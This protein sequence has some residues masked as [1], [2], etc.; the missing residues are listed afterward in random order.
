MQKKL[1][2]LSFLEKKPKTDDT[3][4]ANN[5]STHEHRKNAQTIGNSNTKTNNINIVDGLTAN[6]SCINLTTNIIIASGDAAGILGN[7]MTKEKEMQK[8]ETDE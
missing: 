8:N 4:N 2:M 1:T 7:I 5:N 3:T 6:S